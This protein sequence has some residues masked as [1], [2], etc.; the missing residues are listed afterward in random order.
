MRVFGDQL[1]YRVPGF[2]WGN[3]SVY[4]FTFGNSDLLGVEAFIIG[5]HHQQSM[6]MEFDLVEHRVGLAHARCDLVGQK[7]LGLV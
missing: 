3:D 5:H 6:W 4:C 7:L 1:V 2:V